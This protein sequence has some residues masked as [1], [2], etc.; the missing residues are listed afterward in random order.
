MPQTVAFDEVELLGHHGSDEVAI[1]VQVGDVE[2]PWVGKPQS[3]S[4]LEMGSHVV[5]RAEV[6]CKVDVSSIV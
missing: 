2:Y 5:Q 6:A 4:D 1:R 3:T